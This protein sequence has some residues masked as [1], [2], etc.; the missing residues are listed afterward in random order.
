MA[1][2][3]RSFQMARPFGGIGR[4]DSPT[5]TSD[6]TRTA[7]WFACR[8]IG[9]HLVGVQSKRHQAPLALLGALLPVTALHADTLVLNS[10]RTHLR[11]GEVPEWTEFAQTPNGRRLDL[12]F[13]ARSNATEY[14]LQ[15]RQDDVRQDWPVQLN[16]KRLGKLF[17]MEADLVHTLAIPPG[18]L[19]DGE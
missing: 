7:K 14:T 9:R 12:K 3:R 17:L 19:T 8:A 2:P 4:N 1:R 16:G 13:M 15:I 18:V 5:A 10:G 11:S 6:A